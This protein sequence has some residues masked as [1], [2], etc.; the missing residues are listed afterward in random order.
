MARFRPT[1]SGDES[2]ILIAIYENP[3]MSYD[4]YALT[5]LLTGITAAS[6]DFEAAF[7]KMLK[8][9][10]QLIVRGLVD[11]KQLKGGLGMYYHELKLKYK[12]KQ[13][14]IQERGR[15]AEWNKQLPKIMAESNAVVE[16]MR[17]GEPKK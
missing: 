10:E 8:A 15:I 5:Q 1:Y 4:T 13:E 16:E 7:K 2:K 3:D 12:G 14:A 11:G 17:K 6:P 9:I